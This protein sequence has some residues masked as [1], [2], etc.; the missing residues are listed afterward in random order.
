[1]KGAV[2]CL[3]AFLGLLASGSALS[4][5]ECNSYNDGAC[6]DE[7]RSESTALQT[8]FLKDCPPKKVENGSDITPFC[9]KVQMNIYGTNETLRIQRDCGYE[10]REGYLCYQ[11][12]SEDYIVNVCQCDEDKCNGANSLFFAPVLALLVPLF[13]KFL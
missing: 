5:F 3:S 4:C 7:F 1:M 13:V 9:R 11:K 6:A 12:R 10:R 8:S 2:L